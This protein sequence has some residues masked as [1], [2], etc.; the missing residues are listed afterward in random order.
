MKTIQ[1]PILNSPDIIN[2]IRIS[3]N[4]IQDEM[5]NVEINKVLKQKFPGIN[6]WIIACAI[7]EAKDLF[8]KNK[9]K[10]IIF[11]GK[12]NLK[13]YLKKLI[14]KEEFKENRSKNINIQGEIVR[15]GNRLFTFDFL[16]NKVIFKPSKNIKI[17]IQLPKVKKNIYNQL[18][19]LQRLSD[20]KEITISVKLSRNNISF[21]FDESKLKIY[22]KYQNLKENRILGIDLNPDFIGISVLEF[23]KDDKFKVI[24]K[25]YFDS[26]SLNKKEVSSN[27][28]KFENIEICYSIIKL[29]NEFKVSKLVIEDLSIPSKD[30]K[31]G[32]HI[33]RKVNNVWL[34]NLVRNK[35]KMLCINFGVEFIEV[36]PY[37]SSQIGNIV[38]GDNHTPD[39]IASSIELARRGYKKFQKDWFYPNF[40]YYV[41][42][43]NEQWKQ[44]LILN[45]IKNWK[46]L[47][48]LIK[49]S[50]LKYR[51]LIEDTNPKLSFRKS[52]YK[53][54]IL[55]Y[56]Y[57]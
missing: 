14:T 15:K 8:T 33:N 7:S 35:L 38:F 2:Y 47:F 18:L 41:E 54:N 19:E 16:N 9:D 44:T 11:G 31:I 30:L 20:N 42:K 22:K 46:E 37:Y 29:C 45:N 48:L 43:L 51:I 32:K 34:R 6:S 17:E 53:S 5:N 1:L 26:T 13:R 39:M 49:N 36:L 10:K 55:V 4:R 52:G 56:F 27:K 3:F 24:K 50:K 40:E 28:R 23:S 25:Q 21:T 57:T 12:N